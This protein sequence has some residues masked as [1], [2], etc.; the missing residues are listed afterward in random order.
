M[1]IRA[2]KE[3]RAMFKSLYAAVQA[4]KKQEDLMDLLLSGL[5]V[6]VKDTMDY[7]NAQ[8][9]QG[10][11]IEEF[12]QSYLEM[13]NHDRY[14]WQIFG[15]DLY[16][17]LAEAHPVLPHN[18]VKATNECKFDIELLT[19]KGN[20]QRNWTRALGWFF[21]N[22]YAVQVRSKLLGSSDLEQLKKKIAIANSCDEDGKELEAKAGKAKKAEAKDADKDGLEDCVVEIV[23]RL[24]KADPYLQG[25]FY[26]V[27]LYLTVL[28]LCTDFVPF[29]EN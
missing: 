1:T 26:P 12:R 9:F 2:E 18:I 21:F 3:L 24:S 8:G 11:V 20:V 4:C 22:R 10:P 5:T 6:L 29:N 28:L 17:E 7:I 15:P 27:M 23:G 14:Y 19:K 16:K 25:F 13:M